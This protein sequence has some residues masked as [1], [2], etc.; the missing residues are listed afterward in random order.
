MPQ[1]VIL[2]AACPGTEVSWSMQRRF[3]E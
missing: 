3:S 1:K 2:V